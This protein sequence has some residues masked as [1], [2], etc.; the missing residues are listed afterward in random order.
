MLKRYIPRKVLAMVFVAVV[1]AGI[2]RG[3]LARWFF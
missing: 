3:L 2:V 1:A